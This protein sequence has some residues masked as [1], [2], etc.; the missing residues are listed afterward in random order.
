[1]KTLKFPH[2]FSFTLMLSV[3][4][5]IAFAQQSAVAPPVPKEVALEVTYFKGRILA[6]QRIGESTLYGAFQRPA[7]WKPRPGEVPADAVNISTRLENGIIKARVTVQRGDHY[8]REDFVADYVVSPEGITVIRELSD[9]GIE[10]FEMQ[11]VRAPA[12]VADPPA[13][14]NKTKSLQV[15]VEPRQSTIPMFM[16]RVLNNAAKPVANF[17]YYTSIDS[18]RKLIGSPRN[19]KGGALINPGDTFERTFRYAMQTPTVSTGE[20]PTVLPNLVFNVT[21]VVF[22]DGTYEGEASSA[23]NYLGRNAGEKAMFHRFL[24]M[25]RSK[26]FANS[27]DEADAAIA[28]VNVD[29]I[30]A[31]LAQKFPALTTGEKSGLRG[32]VD[33]GKIFAVRIFRGTTSASNSVLA[34]LLQKRIDSLP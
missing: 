1:M 8:V 3:L 14:V 4:S 10:P 19:E 16:A 2:L 7:D 29:I 25:V 30:A 15:S 23:A 22:T 12:A 32:W 18:S 27:P 5:S 13:V 11:L 31:E 26:E 21:S 28:S 20:V 9:F 33:A 17:S 24:E 34:E 6:Y